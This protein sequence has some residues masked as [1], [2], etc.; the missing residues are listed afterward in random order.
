MTDQMRVAG[1]AYTPDASR[2]LPELWADQLFAALKAAVAGDAHWRTT[3]QALLRTIAATQTPERLAARLR[4]I[5]D[6]KRQAEVMRDLC[7]GQ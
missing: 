6:A 2:I 3:A 1:G 4:E 7:H 5:D